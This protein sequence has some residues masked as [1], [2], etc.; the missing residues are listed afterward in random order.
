MTSTE[1]PDDRVAYDPGRVEA[2]EERLVHTLNAGALCLMTSLGHRTG[3]FDA[4][5]G[6]EPATSGE[7]AREAGLQERYVREWLGAMTVGRIVEHDS[8]AGTYS[9][10]VEHAALITRGASNGNLAVF[11]QYIPMLGGIEDDIVRCFRE[12]GGVPYERYDRFHE[13]M[14]EDSGQTVLPALTSDILPLIPRLTGRLEKGIR[15]LDVGC[16]RGKAV[17]RKSVV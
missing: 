5:A 10:P 6:M 7:I 4:M 2:F 1:Q 3:L 9:L 17:D 14:A 12:G 13:V 8:E 16:G 15:V 11:A